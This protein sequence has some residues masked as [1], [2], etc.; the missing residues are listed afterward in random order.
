M[1]L[2]LDVEVFGNT[3]RVFVDPLAD[4]LVAHAKAH[5]GADGCGIGVQTLIFSFGQV[6]RDEAPTGIC[7]RGVLDHGVHVDAEAVANTGDLDVLVERV[8]VA[9]LGQQTDVAFAVGDLVLA[10]GVVGYVS[11][12]HVFDV[13]N[14]AVEHIGHVHV[15]FV[16][17]GDDFDAGAV[18]A[19]LVRHLM[20]VLGQLV[21]GQ[22]GAGVDG[23]TL[24][25]ATGLEHI[26]GPLP[27][28]VGGCG[29]KP[30][31]VK[32]VFSGVRVGRDRHFHARTS[33]GKNVI[34][35]AF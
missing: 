17:G 16:I 5:Q 20:D 9:I 21:D 7:T 13:A 10:S 4:R 34:G 6:F 23:L 26:G 15:G 35:T 11:I 2:V 29:I 27:L 18:H 3:D 28:V 1:L 14:D 22:A 32:L 12:A 33:N 31:V 24:D 19:L 8:L 25:S 30:Q